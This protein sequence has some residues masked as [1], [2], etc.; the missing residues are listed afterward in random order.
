VTHIVVTGDPAYSDGEVVFR[1]LESVWR[2]SGGELIDIDI[3]VSGVLAEITRKIIADNSELGITESD[4]GLPADEVFYFGY[5][6]SGPSELVEAAIR[7]GIPTTEF[8]IP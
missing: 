1:M 7:L 6:D 8:H 5:R 2:C 4:I 3:S